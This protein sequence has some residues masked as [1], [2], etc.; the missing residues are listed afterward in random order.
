M[1]F[2]LS[3][4]A[5]CCCAILNLVVQIFG[6]T[7]HVLLVIKVGD[8]FN[9]K[10]NFASSQ[11]RLNDFDSFSGTTAKFSHYDIQN[12]WTIQYSQTFYS[13]L[14]ICIITL[15]EHGIQV[16]TNLIMRLKNPMNDSLSSKSKIIRFGIVKYSSARIDQ[17]PDICYM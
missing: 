13:D 10:C 12:R 2:Q 5:E 17:T 14:R 15:N 7:K 1:D 8:Y 9:T 6:L 11:L 3:Y 16:L 4:C